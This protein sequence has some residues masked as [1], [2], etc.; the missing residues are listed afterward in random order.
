M[1]ATVKLQVNVLNK[2]FLIQ[3]DI[4]NWA[5]LEATPHQQLAA[6]IYGT[7]SPWISEGEDETRTHITSHFQHKGVYYIPR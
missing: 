5:F 1:Q 6:E 7:Q 4:L 2:F 3:D